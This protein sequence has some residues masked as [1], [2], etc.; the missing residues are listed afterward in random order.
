MKKDAKSNRDR[1]AN[2]KNN[3]VT[4]AS[5]SFAA[6]KVAD[7][8][9]KAA[10]TGPQQYPNPGK[11]VKKIE[12]PKP[13]HTKTGVMRVEE[14]E[15]IDEAGKKCWK[16]YKKK[17]TQTLFGKTYNRC[18]KANE[19][20]VD[21]MIS[22]SGVRRYD[23]PEAQ[24]SIRQRKEKEQKRKGR[25]SPER[26]PEGNRVIRG[27]DAKGSYKMVKGVKFYEDKE[28][29]I[30]EK[31]DVRKQSS[32]RKSLGRG[33]SINPDAKKTG[34]ESPA[35][36]RK[37]EKKLAPYMNKEG[38][39]PG[40]VDQKVGAVTAIPKKEQDAAKARL[41]AKAKAKREKMGEDFEKEVPSG[42]IKKLVKKAVKRIDQNV[43]GHVDKKD[44]SM[45]EYGEFVPSPDGKSRVVTSVK[46]ESF[47]DWRSDLGED[48]QK[49]NR[50]DGVDGMSQ[51]SV[52]AYKRENPS[53]KLQTAV[54]GNPKKGSK[55]AKRRSS[56]CSRSEGQKDMHNIDCS[57]T[58]DKAI[59]KARRRWKC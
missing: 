11:G 18:V 37:T 19:E 23:T 24:K 31:I 40:D 41:L 48:W 53:S 49:S 57:K 52:D 1:A 9:K 51:S 2:M 33:S 8:V 13:T 50:K 4:R 32:K 46:R 59:C 12:K 55:D 3:R 47:S 30:D 5:A 42:D 25:L 6:A 35:E 26:T 54:T 58:P 17:G 21:E 39:A 44:K 10:K 20:V 27:R 14:V 45:G 7:D 29:V 28:K 43:S 34:Y 36:F 38:Y 15:S 22:T 16:G 56:Y